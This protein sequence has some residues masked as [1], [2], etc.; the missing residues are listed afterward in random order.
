MSSN[1]SFLEQEFPVLAN[2]GRLAEEYCYS[3]SNSC[4]MKLGMIGETIVN[5][6]FTYDRIALPADNT[7]VKRIDTLYR[8]GLLTQDLVDILHAL[9][10][11]RNKAVHENYASVADGKALLPMAH[12]L[13]EWFM[14]TYGDWNYQHHEFVMPA[15]QQQKAMDKAAEEQ[16]ETRLTQEAEKKAAQTEAISKDSR[17]KRASQTASQRQKTEAE[18]RYIIDQQLRQVGWEADTE[19][20]RF[21]KGTRPVKGRNLAIAEWPT[22]STVGNHGRADYALFIGLQFVGIIE[23]KAEHKDMGIDALYLDEVQQKLFVVQSKWRS[24]GVGSADQD[25]MN[26]FAQGIQRILDEDVDGANPK[27]SAK[28]TD[29]D[30]ALT[31]MG[32]QIYSIFI[33]TGNQK[34]NDYIKRSISRLMAQTNDDMS[35]ILL[36]EEFDFRNVFEFLAKGQEQASIDIDDV[37]LS[38]WGRISDPFTAYYGT[39]SASTVGKWYSDFGNRLFAKNIRFYKGNTE[40]NEGMKKVL[41]REP[42]K[43]YY[44][45]NGIKLLCQSIQRKAKD[46]TTNTTGLFALKGVSL[47]NG[48]QTTGTVGAVFTDSPEQVS[49]AKIMV[50][51]IDLSNIDPETAVQITRLSNTQNRIENKD[52]AALDPVQDK[53]RT[54]L[55]F[56]HYSYLY[57]SGDSITNPDK[58]ISFDE[59]MIAL[60][61]LHN[62]ISYTVIAKSN[63]GALSEDITKTPY[64]ALINPSTNSYA[65]LNAVLYTRE[66]EHYLQSRR[67]QANSNRERLVCIHGNR[68]IEHFVLQKVSQEDIFNTAVIDKGSIQGTIIPLVDNCLIQTTRI[69]G[70]LFPESYPANIFKNTTKCKVIAER[71]SD[72]E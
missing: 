5:L 49:K 8:E 65:L 41:L 62:E 4:L 48:A 43:F 40:V 34:A 33:H 38:N 63:V 45:N 17:R 54:E 16:T 2:F 57:K 68:F 50:Q 30:K 53:L 35:T 19:N 21:S 25:E 60:D 37:I 23:A 27:I 20:L 72:L 69:I 12:S 44:Y 58:Q 1:F 15:P 26:S 70:E 59:V 61:C 47:V 42:E 36:F 67:E 46:S 3:D 51:I 10:K 9:R 14:Q 24:N 56:A 31:Q 66:I 7:A 18:T 71:I 6:M 39:I 52:F 55:T 28:S 13:C 64:K 29:I 22:D 32:Y 11:V